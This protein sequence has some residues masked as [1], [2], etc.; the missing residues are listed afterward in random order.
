MNDAEPNPEWFKHYDTG[1]IPDAWR[2]PHFWPEI[3]FRSVLQAKRAQIYSFPEECVYSKDHQDL[4]DDDLAATELLKA[5]SEDGRSFYV[6][7][8]LVEPRYS[9]K[10]PARGAKRA[11]SARVSI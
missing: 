2:N 8:Q 10:K 7:H 6:F 3:Q 4:Q 11:A 1:T 9:S 5:S